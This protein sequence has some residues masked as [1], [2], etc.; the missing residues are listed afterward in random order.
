MR[1]WIFKINNHGKKIYSQSLQDGII[2][3]IFNNL[4]TQ[5]KPPFCVDLIQIL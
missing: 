1:N 5:N 3:F 2:E 4:Q